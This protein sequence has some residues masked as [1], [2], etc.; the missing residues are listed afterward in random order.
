MK[1]INTQVPNIKMKLSE[2][3]NL[4]EYERQTVSD[5]MELSISKLSGMFVCLFVN[6]KG[7]RR[8]KRLG[9]IVNR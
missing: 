1:A 4:T 5:I 6:L 7:K 8:E 9:W 2:L 3:H